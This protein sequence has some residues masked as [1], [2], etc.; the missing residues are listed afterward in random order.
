[1]R[2][3]VMTNH[4]AELAG[5]EVV[6]S[7]VALWF[8]ERGDDVSLAANLIRAPM[9]NLAPQLE[10]LTDI[11]A[12]DLSRFDLVWC[13]HGL[14]S[15]LPLSAIEAAGAAPPLVALASLSPFEPYEHLDG[16]LANALT[17]SI[18]ANSPETADEIVRR[19]HGLIR[20]DRV[21]V[22]H[23][24][25]PAAFWRAPI[26][27][28][29]TLKAII[30]VSNHAPPELR[31]ACQR[32]QELGIH[33]RH[34]GLHDEYCRVDAGAIDASDAVISIGKSVV[35]GIARQ[36]P[37]YIYDQYGGD[38]WLTRANFDRNVAHNFSGR[39]LRRQLDAET[40][41]AELTGGF[42]D[43]VTEIEHIRAGQSLERFH[44]D[45]YLEPLRARALR[46]A[47]WR[48]LTLRRS[49]AS[50][51]FCAHLERAHQNA[52]VMRRSY[53]KGQSNHQPKG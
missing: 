1:M 11:S 41:V 21:D 5:S 47:L 40:I 31:A 49:L 36:R 19:N 52:L 12:I 17:A 44:L 37:V 39:P 29:R 35:Y 26:A 28:Q 2:V 23:N 10:L 53:L 6:A 51:T 13:Q 9:S 34:I 8:L 24:A 18:F 4:F 16:S 20:R 27:R 14:L 30:V 50:P 33:V 22:F 43:A 7:E 3:L 15:L 25:A 42:A 45:T 48:A 32:F 46:P 38:G